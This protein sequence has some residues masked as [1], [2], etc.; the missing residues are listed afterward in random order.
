MVDV[1]IRRDGDGLALDLGNVDTGQIAT[2]HDLV[3]WVGGVTEVGG[4]L[5]GTIKVRIPCG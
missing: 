3:R 2:V 4:G 5:I 1:V